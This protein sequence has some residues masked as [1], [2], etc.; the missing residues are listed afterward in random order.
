VSATDSPDRVEY[1]GKAAQGRE[2]ACC[3]GYPQESSRPPR[4]QFSVASLDV[5]FM[6]RY[7]QIR[8]IE[9]PKARG[10]VGCET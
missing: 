5:L 3:P 9:G 8:P 7:D 1:R 2:P 10:I 6:F 4:E